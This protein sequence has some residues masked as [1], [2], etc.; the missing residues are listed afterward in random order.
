MKER[1]SK[2][3]AKKDAK[4]SSVRVRPETQKRANQILQTAN[5]K[6]FGRKV[7]ID[8]LIE[9]A[10]S[11]VADEHIKLLQEKSMTNED[12][13]EILRQKYI[14]S[15]GPITK[16]EFTGFMMSSSFQEFLK[17]ADSAEIVA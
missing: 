4:F 12:R 7:K 10:L 11:L 9:L 14:E 5:K 15:Q 2:S 6:Q 3:I 1:V 13:K 16:D 17:E 8:N